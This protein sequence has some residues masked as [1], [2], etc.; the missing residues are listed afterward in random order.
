MSWHLNFSAFS[1]QRGEPQCNK[2]QNKSVK[3]N[4]WLRILCSTQR[5]SVKAVWSCTEWLYQAKKKTLN[6]HHLRQCCFWLSKSNTV[7][8]FLKYLHAS[9]SSKRM[10]QV[11]VSNFMVCDKV[12]MTIH[13]LTKTIISCLNTESPLCLKILKSNLLL[14]L[15]TQSFIVLLSG[16]CVTSE[17]QCGL[18]LLAWNQLCLHQHTFQ[19]CH[20]FF[21]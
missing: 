13:S 11:S 21:F 3:L 12:K 17:L 8:P 19:V 18:D 5:F 14:P 7:L 6:R 2:P 16:D 4:V 20:P 9:V 10:I 1:H 15:F